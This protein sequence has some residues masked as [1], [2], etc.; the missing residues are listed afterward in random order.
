MGRL[1]AS[2]LLILL[3]PITAAVG[4]TDAEDDVGNYEAGQSFPVHAPYIDI[5]NVSMEQEGPELVLWMHLADRVSTRP[6][7]ARLGYLFI[8]TFRGDP[9]R[10][11]YEQETHTVLCTVEAS[12]ACRDTNPDAD[13]AFEVAVAGIHGAAVTSRLRLEA[14]SGEW[15]IGAATSQTIEGNVTAQDFTDN[16]LPFQAG[17]EPSP[18][19]TATTP[20]EPWWQTWRLWA[21]LFGAAVVGGYA[22][23]RVRP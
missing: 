19:F 3:A 1:G 9:S 14:P 21:L 16:A 20:D 10:S 18:T 7:D 22:W 15:L 2:L 12:I 6:S 13:D 11:L 5:L 8:F 23:K 4:V 17:P